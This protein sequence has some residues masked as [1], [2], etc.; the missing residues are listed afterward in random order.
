MITQ[1]CLPLYTSLEYGGLSHEI[2][3]SCLK[4]VL[5][6]RAPQPADSVELDGSAPRLMIVVDID[7]ATMSSIMG[8]SWSQLGGETV[9]F[10]EF[11]GELL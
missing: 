10:L 5:D 6:V 9:K 1:L 7:T 4:R 11:P 2:L 8:E 3:A